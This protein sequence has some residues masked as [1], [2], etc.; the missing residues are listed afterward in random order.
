MWGLALADF[1]RNPRSSDSLRGI[2]FS[3]KRKNCSQNVQILSLLVYTRA[4][5]ASAG[6]SRRCVSLC[7][8][9]T[10]QY[11]AKTANCR[12]ML[13]K[14]SLS[15]CR[16]C[17]D[18]A[19]NLSLLKRRKLRSNSMHER[20]ARLSRSLAAQADI[21]YSAVDT[22]LPERCWRK[23]RHLNAQMTTACQSFD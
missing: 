18:R 14:R 16:Y 15:N 8:S 13:E 21:R 23:A 11:C 4:T 5:L 3:K 19:Q 20:T 2:V 7:V 9:V 17:V 22:S 1:G 10:R 6:I 12:I